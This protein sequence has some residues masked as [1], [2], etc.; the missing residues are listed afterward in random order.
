LSLE[1]CTGA[2]PQETIQSPFSQQVTVPA[3]PRLESCLSLEFCLGAPPQESIP[4][5]TFLLACVLQPH[6]GHRA[7]LST[8]VSSSQEF[9]FTHAK[10]FSNCNRRDQ[11][12]HSQSLYHPTSLGFVE[13]RPISYDIHHTT[14]SHLH[15]S[16]ENPTTPPLLFTIPL[17]LPTPTKPLSI[18]PQSPPSKP[19]IHHIPTPHFHTP[20]HP[21]THTPCFLLLTLLLPNFVFFIHSIKFNFQST[22]P[23]FHYLYETF[24]ATFVLTTPS[25]PDHDKLVILNRM[26]STHS[27]FALS[28]TFPTSSITLPATYSPTTPPL[29]SPPPQPPP[30][31]P[32]PPDCVEIDPNEHNKKR[33][34]SKSRTPQKQ[35]DKEKPP[36]LK[37]KT[38]T[39]Q[40]TK[41]FNCYTINIRGLTQ[42]KWKAILN[43]PSTKDPHAIV[44][45]EHH[46]PFGHTPSYVTTS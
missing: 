3:L 11:Q 35:R 9:S 12:Q 43:H 22:T 14:L 30:D 27:Y 21:T 8:F 46:L 13:Q 42:Q 36:Q 29:P 39:T 19:T 45:T 33:R 28:S 44:V 10:L 5:P 7:T 6:G 41:P 17:R 1:L 23:P 38:S 34:R 16:I 18:P 32:S 40:H 25:E 31:P 15:F 4:H 20:T 26:T 2:P 37:K 24:H